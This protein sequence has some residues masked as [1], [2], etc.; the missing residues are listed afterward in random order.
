VPFTTL[1]TA[2]RAPDGNADQREL[3]AIHGTYDRPVVFA[4]AGRERVDR[5]H[6]HREVP[7]QR[8]LVCG[9]HRFRSPQR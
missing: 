3:V 6:R 5:E 4:V 8:S 1:F 9:T 7:A 2:L